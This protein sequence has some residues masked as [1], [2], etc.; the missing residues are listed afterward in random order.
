MRVA[1]VVMPFAAADRPSLAAGLLAAA[2]EEAGFA[3]DV[4]HFN[5]TLAKLVGKETYHHLSHELPA[6]V[7]GC[8]RV[9]REVL[10]G[11]DL[12]PRE[13]YEREVLDDPVWGA[14]ATSR[15][16]LDA[17]RGI[18]PLFLGLA[19]GT[20]DWSAYDVVGF[21][22][23]FEQT[24]PSLALAARIKAAHPGV[25]IVLGGANFE[26]DM[27]A[28]YLNRFPFVDL[29]AAGES[30]IAFPALLRALG[31]GTAVPAGFL[32]RGPSG[33]GTRPPFVNLDAL[34]MPR[35]DEF[36]SVLDATFPEERRRTWISVEASRGCWWGQVS[37]CT[38]CGLNG[39]GMAFRKKG[40]ERVLAET[41]ALSARYGAMPLAFADNI[42][43]MDAF[44]D[45]LPAWAARPAKT[46]KF[47]E[48]K[49]NLR[50]SQ[51]LALRDAGITSVQAGVESLSDSTLRVMRKGVSGAQNL[52]LLRWL[53]EAG[54]ESLWNVLYG[55][56]H[57]EPE[58]YAE[59]LRLLRAIPHLTPPSAVAP[60][61][62][63][64]FSPNHSDSAAHGFANVRAMPAYRHVFPFDEA[65][66]ERAATFFRYD[67]PGMSDAL[68]KGNE[69]ARE[70]ARWRSA[71]AE[72]RAGELS[73]AP[74]FPSGTALVD[75][76]YT[77]TGAKGHERVR[78]LP[79]TELAMLLAC[80][81]PISPA[82][83]ITRVVESGAG[84]AGSAETAL[85]RLVAGDVIARAGDLLVTLALLPQQL[86]R[87]PL[88]RA[89]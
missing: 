6:T 38:F 71:V 49:S 50:R 80:D 8:E 19:Y 62:M 89:D 84:D 42:L 21:T 76:R 7:L 60:I 58:S 17:L 14:G 78:P 56:P 18:A 73:V 66:R 37:H 64:R 57:E 29:I 24:M 44:R 5:L 87:P 3:C 22:S 61:R 13:E 48:I 68:V 46:P 25:T 4:K 16:A 69:L 34:P 81:A 54:L 85:S 67:H 30:D 9:F 36:Y 12:T 45:L 41:D 79:G 40:F 35:F 10:G 15:R 70:A 75:T 77:K 39:Q 51:V 11:Q 27:G 33:S 72:K 32:H 20:C 55:F 82:R 65:E 88:A 74:R 43:S 31:E 26:G 23:T 47:F 63:D 52:A 28:P 83:A 59:T 2:A 1:L 53:H 86:D